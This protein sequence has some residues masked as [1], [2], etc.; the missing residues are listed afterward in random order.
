[1]TVVEAGVVVEP[2]PEPL[3]EPE[4]ELEPEVVPEPEVDPEE[5]PEELEPPAEPDPVAEDEPEPDDEPEPELPVPAFGLVD[6]LVLVEPPWLGAGL[7]IGEPELSTVGF[8]V[9][10]VLLEVLP[11]SDTRE[12][13][14]ATADSTPYL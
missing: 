4:P 9:A 7:A 8:V 14:W 2:E 13:P 1:V 10:M 12:L 11:P 3:A 5:E 6:G